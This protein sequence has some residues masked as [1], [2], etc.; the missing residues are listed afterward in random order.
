MIEYETVTCVFC[1]S[2]YDKVKNKTSR[3][4]IKTGI[5]GANTVTCST[6]CSKLHHINARKNKCKCGKFKQKAS[7]HCAKCMGLAAR[8]DAFN[9]GNT[10][11]GVKE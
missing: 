2:P 10:N 4:R 8:L 6:R 9:H 7:R 11:K 1:N 3:S 5:R